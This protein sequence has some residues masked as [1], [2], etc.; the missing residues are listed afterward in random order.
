MFLFEEAQVFFITRWVSPEDFEEHTP[1][2]YLCQPVGLMTSGQHKKEDVFVIT[3][4]AHVLQPRYPSWDDSTEK[5]LKENT[6]VVSKSSNFYSALYTTSINK[7]AY[8]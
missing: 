3:I 8:D 5:T 7:L 4:S 6:R 1:S 2:L